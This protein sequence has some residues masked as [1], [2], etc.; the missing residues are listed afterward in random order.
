MICTIRSCYND[1]RIKQG[2]YCDYHWM[3]LTPANRDELS[4]AYVD[5][6][7]QACPSCGSRRTG[8]FCANCG[9]RLHGRGRR[10]WLLWLA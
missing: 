5:S 1:G 9:H 10:W 8:R 3:K 6:R 4:K 7:R 2:G